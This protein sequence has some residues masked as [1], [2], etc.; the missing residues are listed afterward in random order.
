MVSLTLESLFKI[1][2]LPEELLA[3][4]DR[5]SAREFVDYLKVIRDDEREIVERYLDGLDGWRREQIVMFAEGKG[6]FRKNIFY[7]G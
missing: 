7:Y 2:V 6:Y 3:R 4:F 5:M 1:L